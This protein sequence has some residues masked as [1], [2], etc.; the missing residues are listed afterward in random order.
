[1]NSVRRLLF[2][3]TTALAVSSHAQTTPVIGA[4]ITPPRRVAAVSAEATVQ[5]PATRARLSAMIEVQAQTPADAQNVVRQRSQTLLAFLQ[6]AGVDDLQAGAMA[7]HPVY[8]PPR[9]AASSEEALPEVVAYRAQWRASFEVPAERA[10]EIV[11]GLAG[12]G[13]AR[14]AGFDFT[15]TE[16]E[17]AEARQRALSRAALKAREEARGVLQTLG[18]RDGDVV[19]VEVEHGGPVFP[20]QR[21]M[22][23]MAF[24]KADGPTA[25]S[26]GLI[27]VRAS[28][29]LE[30]AY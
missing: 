17:L 6:R 10:G 18:Y 9:K 1:M 7:L 25:V 29:R 23:M 22:E 27:D 24:A 19:R 30:L 12:A 20:M 3:A 14:I 5:I 15:A 21:G 11:D 28:V 26:P 8:G 4:E 13:A 16:R 2:L